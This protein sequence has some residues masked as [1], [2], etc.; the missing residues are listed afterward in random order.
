MA[1][2]CYDWVCYDYKFES[3]AGRITAILKQTDFMKLHL[4]RQ[5][6]NHIGCVTSMPFTSRLARP[7]KT[8][9]DQQDRHGPARTGKTYQDQEGDQKDTGKDQPDQQRPNR[10]AKTKQTSKDQ[11]KM[12]R[13]AKL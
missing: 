9:K 10:P 1:I 3:T 7:G 12:A 4:L 13:P 11:Q 6:V 8:D 5:T 2:L